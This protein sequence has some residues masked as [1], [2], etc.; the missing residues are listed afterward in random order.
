M[1]VCIDVYGGLGEAMNAA[2]EH[3][4]DAKDLYGWKDTGVDWKETPT[5][6]IAKRESYRH[7]VYDSLLTKIT[8]S[9]TGC[10]KDGGSQARSRSRGTTREESEMTH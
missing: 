8:Q 9:M 4:D 1:N 5:K 3:L 6:T 7:S 10:R 2:R